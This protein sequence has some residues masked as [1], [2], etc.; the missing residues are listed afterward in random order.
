MKRLFS[1][2]HMLASQRLCS[3]AYEIL[4]AMIVA[5]VILAL[6]FLCHVRAVEVNGTSMQ[7]TFDQGQRLLVVY[8]KQYTYGDV[9]VVDR[10]VQE[11][12]IK[13]VIAVGGDTLDIDASGAVY[14]NGEQLDEPYCKGQTVLRDFSGPL[15][16]PEGYVFV[17]G[18][19]RTVSLDSRSEAIGLILEKDLVGKIV[20]QITPLDRFGK[21]Q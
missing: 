8:E 16:I 18:D 15:V 21:V 20:W 2:M 14:R 10:Y 13:R 1:K 11:P 6:C 19:N 12:L 7:P 3:L 9:V 17:M 4:S 5:I